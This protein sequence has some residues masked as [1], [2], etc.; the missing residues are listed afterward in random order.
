MH[1][2]R[3]SPGFRI[4]IWIITLSLSCIILFPILWIFT[5]SITPA[6]EL[7]KSPVD[8]IPKHPTFENYRQLIRDCGLA[9]K[10]GYTMVI[11]FS[12]MF[13]NLMI[14]LMAAYGF[15]RH[16][17]RGLSIA[18]ALIVF[19]ILVPAVVK[20]RPL[21]TFIRA[22]GLYDTVPGLI[23]LYTSNLIPF[24]M[25]I[26]SNFLNDIPM[27]IDEAAEIDGVTM[28]QKLMFIIFPLMRPAIATILMINFINCL[29]D[30]FT[31]LFYASRIQTLSVAITTL[32]SV[33]GYSIPWELV[34][35]M[36]WVIILPII[37]F[38]SIFERQIMD[39][40]MAGGVKA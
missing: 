28:L 13:L 19:S 12:A 36:G 23:I 38:V 32:P 27:A 3:R 18:F 9:S 8:Y 25:I 7:F 10:F 6:G 35:S 20:A 30:L 34:S 37:I 22:V 33:D 2:L 16:K 29:N 26:L 21:F 17:S 5:S 1:A 40:I 31:P 39:G 4:Y 24:S 11:S 15:S 14:C